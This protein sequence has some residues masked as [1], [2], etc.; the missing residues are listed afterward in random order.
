MLIT[1]PG[2]SNRTSRD[3]PAPG[4]LAAA[5]RQ[6]CVEKRPPCRPGMLPRSAPGRG[7]P[8]ASGGGHVFESPGS[9]VVDLVRVERLED[10]ERTSL[11]VALLLAKRRPASSDERSRASSP[12]AS[13]GILTHTRVAPWRS[14]ASMRRLVSRSSPI[15]AS[16]D[17]QQMDGPAVLASGQVEALRALLTGED[18]DVAGRNAVRLERLDRRH[19]RLLV[20][21]Q[22]G[23]PVDEREEM[24]PRVG[25]AVESG[26]GLPPCKP[27][28]Q[29]RPGA[30]NVV[31]QSKCPFGHLRR[32]SGVPRI[33]LVK[34]DLGLYTTSHPPRTDFFR[35]TRPA[36]LARP[37]PSATTRA[38][39]CHICP[40]ELY[41]HTL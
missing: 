13:T 22:G 36:F 37:G 18:V 34:T 38:R 20:V 16:S 5:T 14:A 12:A 21:E 31:R 6:P 17:A 25:I 19:D 7:S 2:S 8:T 26:H 1:H 27:A 9:P 39:A 33:P 23:H 40:P 15:A 29:S 4:R 11:L 10:P 32:S 24:P 30:E 35:T 3:T 41:S 28:S